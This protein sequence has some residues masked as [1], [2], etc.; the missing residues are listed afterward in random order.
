[1]LAD[2]ADQTDPPLERLRQVLF[3]FLHRRISQ[4][5]QTEDVDEDFLPVAS[6]GFVVRK[7]KAGTPD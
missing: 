6:P 7:G 5:L 2:S 4:H 3:L 1:M